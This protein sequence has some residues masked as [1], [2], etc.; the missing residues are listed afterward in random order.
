MS[1]GM[2]PFWGHILKQA[3]PAFAPEFATHACL[4]DAE[5][6]TLT[7]NSPKVSAGCPTIVRTVGST[8][9]MENMEMVF[10]PGLTATICCFV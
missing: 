7:G 2:R 3:I 9:E 10:E 1:S 5:R 6:A 4:R 8:A